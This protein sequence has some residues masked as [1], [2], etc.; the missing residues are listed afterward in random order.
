MLLNDIVNH[1]IRYRIIF[2]R[3]NLCFR[4]GIVNFRSSSKINRCAALINLVFG[5]FRLSHAVQLER[6]CGPFTGI[7]AINRISGNCC[8]RPHFSGHSTNRHIFEFIILNGNALRID[9]LFVFGRTD[10]I[11][12][13]CKSISGYLYRL[14]RSSAIRIDQY[15]CLIT[16]SGISGI[17][18]ECTICHFHRT[19]SGDINV[20]SRI[21][22]AE[23]Q[24]RYR[25]I[26]I[27]S[28][29]DC[30]CILYFAKVDRS[31]FITC[32]HNF[33]RTFVIF[34]FRTCQFEH[35]FSGL[36]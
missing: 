3:R 27:M 17:T 25:N 30:N 16:S 26:V 4:D 34:G 2:H 23:F 10:T 6:K 15:R 12:K 35:H 21:F 22:I 13:I 31:L 28:H 1:G 7:T 9:L 18:L 8:T 20:C 5:N 33:F 24:I 14:T 29:I 32:D 11:F 36:Q 19:A